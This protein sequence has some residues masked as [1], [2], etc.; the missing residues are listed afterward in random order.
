M[1]HRPLIVC[2]TPIAYRRPRRW[3][4]SRAFLGVGSHL[5]CPHGR[6]C[7]GTADGAVVHSWLRVILET[8]PCYKTCKTLSHRDISFVDLRL[9][10]PSNRIGLSTRYKGKRGAGS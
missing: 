2:G 5:R 3:A 1:G 9:Y 4:L 8:S 10:F 7:V 6:F